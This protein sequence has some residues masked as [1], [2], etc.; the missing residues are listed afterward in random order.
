MHS[1]LILDYPVHMKMHYAIFKIIYKICQYAYSQSTTITHMQFNTSLIT[2]FSSLEQI[3]ISSPMAYNT[4]FIPYNCVIVNTLTY[5]LTY[6][7]PHLPSHSYQQFQSQNT[8]T[9][10]VHFI[11]TG[12]V[13][14][15][16]KQSMWAVHGQPTLPT[17]VPLYGIDFHTHFQSPTYQNIVY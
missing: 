9:F 4:I 6:L 17:S 7:F 15:V 10:M 3:I 5:V 12:T 1:H 16:S 11:Q 8:W 14:T 13:F 2:Q